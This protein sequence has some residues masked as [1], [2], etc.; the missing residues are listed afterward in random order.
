MN[1][2]T[3][4]VSGE[5]NAIG[6]VR[7]MLMYLHGGPKKWGH[8]LMTTILSNLSRFFFTERFPG[9]IVVKRIRLLAAC[10]PGAQRVWPICLPTLYNGQ[11]ATC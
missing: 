5:D 3:D 10:W 8:R 2:I 7:R 9:K 1:L 6:R 11:T 4:S